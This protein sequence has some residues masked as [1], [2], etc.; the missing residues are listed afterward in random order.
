MNKIKAR[1]I[2]VGSESERFMLPYIRN[3]LTDA[4]IELSSQSYSAFDYYNHNKSKCIELKTRNCNSSTYPTT[5]IPL[6][7][8]K[9][10]CDAKNQY[11]FFF[12]FND[13]VKYI[14]YD[15]STF[16]KFEIK[17]GGRSDRGRIESNDY[18]YI[19]VKKCQTLNIV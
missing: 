18:L 13:N 12:R 15:A 10:C 7:K 9:K 8:I 17:I 2:I 11:Y 19:P 5:M 16:D 4:T 14:K 1:D 6:S 3:V